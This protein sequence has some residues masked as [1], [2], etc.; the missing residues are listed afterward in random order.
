MPI[1]TRYQYLLKCILPVTDVLVLNAAYFVAYYCAGSLGKEVS[2]EIH[3]DNI[4]VCT[5]L[6]LLCTALCG[7][8]SSFGMQ[9][10]ERIYRGTLRSVALHFVLF[11]VYILFC[12]EGSF[13]RTFLV[14]FYSYLSVGFLISRFVGTSIEYLILNRFK[15]TRVVAVMG[16]AQMTTK[17]VSYLEAQKTVSIYGSIGDD[18]CI[19]NSDN[20]ALMES[21]NARLADAVKSGV[22]DVF[23]AINP[24]RMAEVH[25]L[26]LAAEQ[27]CVRLKFIPDLAGSF[28]SPFKVTHLDGQFP[29]ITLRDEPLEQMENRVKKRLMDLII[30]GAVIIFLLSWLLPIIA[31]LIRMQ[32]KGPALF[33]QL[34]TGRNDIPF[35]CYKFR[36]MRL[37]ADSDSKQATRNDDRITP[38]GRFLRS[39]SLDEL[40]QFFNVFLGEMSVV[41]PR[42]HMLQHKEQYRSIVN[43]YMTRHFLKPGITGWAQVNG[44]RGEMRSDAD[45]ANRIKCDIYYL[46]NW[47]AMFDVKIIF[48]TVLNMIRGDEH[49]Y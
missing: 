4:L 10:L 47:T 1:Q 16:P 45:M 37:N 20:P 13:S 41:G 9:S 27:Q 18:E 8:Y 28:A 19:Y 12:R 44:F 46:E 39:T 34:R 11:T 22:K 3:R 33:K 23:V 35:Y 17:I 40:P 43:Q 31:I 29:I 21:L 5:L 24:D 6:W 49:A 26:I 48:L 25:G 15:A 2:N 30:S 42:P 7:L 32:S 36:S 14:L 38:I